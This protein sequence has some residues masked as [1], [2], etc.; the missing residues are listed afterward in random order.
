MVIK[1]NNK[2]SQKLDYALMMSETKDPFRRE[3]G[4]V[5]KRRIEKQIF[6]LEEKIEEA[7]KVL[8]ELRNE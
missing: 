8:R 3:A 6:N 1:F 4:R 5:F 7:E 2:L